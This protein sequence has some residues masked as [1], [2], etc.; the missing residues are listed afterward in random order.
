MTDG[1][2]IGEVPLVT[3]T[4]I[5]SARDRSHTAERPPIQRNAPA[6]FAAPGA[7]GAR[8]AERTEKEDGWH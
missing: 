1:R 7:A 2:L 4:A 8:A 6:R 3:D 5:V